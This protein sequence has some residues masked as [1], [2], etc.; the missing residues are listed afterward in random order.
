MLIKR[1][2][3]IPYS[4]ITPKHMYLNRRSF[5]AALPLAGAALAARN[6]LADN[7]LSGIAKSP[8]STT[9]NV[10]PYNDVTHYNN[11]YEFGTGK[12]QPAS[13]ARLSNTTSTW[14]TSR[15]NVS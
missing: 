11:Y 9:E 7:K 12:D 13:L 15:F 3:D 5:L 10:T 14:R 1:A 4:E 6:A 2:P 8:F